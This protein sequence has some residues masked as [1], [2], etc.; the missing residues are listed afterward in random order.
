MSCHLVVLLVRVLLVLWGLHSFKRQ[1]SLSL[2]LSEMAD[3]SM[4]STHT[5]S[6]TEVA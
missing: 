6:Y 4:V 1:D 2:S 5:T 3:R